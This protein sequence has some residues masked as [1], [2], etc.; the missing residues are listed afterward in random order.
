MSDVVRTTK[1]NYI[2]INGI[3]ICQDYDLILLDDYSLPLP[4]Y[5]SYTI[6]IP[7]G[8]SVVDLTEYAGDIVYGQRSQTFN[9]VAIG[10]TQQSIEGLRTKLATLFHGRKYTYVLS[11]DTDYIYTGRF[12]FGAPSYTYGENWWTIPL[13]IAAEPYKVRFDSPITMVFNAAG[14]V[15]VVLPI[16]RKLVCPTI[17]VQRESVV[18]HGDKTWTLEPGASKIRNLWLSAT[19]PDLTVNT[20][21]EYSAT[22]LGDYADDVLSIL[23]E[24]YPRIQNVAAGDMP[25]QAPDVLSIYAGDVLSTFADT[26]LVELEHPATLGDE[27]SVYVQYDYETL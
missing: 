20:Y 3:D 11:M 7:G 25:A 12:K 22:T 5:K 6:D 13:T 14:G 1:D 4:D 17:E 18:S 26:R 24:T 8:N 9:L 21:P 15:D 16:G 19:D 10:Y 27:Y 23:E 2:I